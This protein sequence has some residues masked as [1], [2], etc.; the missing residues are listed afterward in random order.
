MD[1]ITQA[2]TD[3]IDHAYVPFVYQDTFPGM[4]IRFPK[5]VKVNILEI[6]RS[7]R[8]SIKTYNF[9]PQYRLNTIM[10]IN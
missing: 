2:E 10:L 9:C 5:G 6:N 8:Y 1:I 7:L 3:N 4:G